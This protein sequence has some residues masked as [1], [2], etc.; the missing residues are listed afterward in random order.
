MDDRE[1]GATSAE[2]VAASSAFQREA[3]RSERARIVGILSILAAVFVLIVARAFLAGLSWL[4]I[5]STVLLAVVAA[6]ESG[7]L[8]AVRTGIRNDR[9]LP[10]WSWTLNVVV[11]TLLPTIALL[12]LTESDLVGPYQALVAPAVLTYFFFITLSTLR[13]S[14]PLALVTGLSSAIGQV[15]DASVGDTER[16]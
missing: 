8:W 7:M 1:A 13:L 3:M 6:Y 2:S 5:Q 4:L 14:P 16:T 15:P 12:I 11:E 10:G 9:P